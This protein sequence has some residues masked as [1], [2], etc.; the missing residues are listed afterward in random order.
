MEM[1]GWQPDNFWHV[2]NFAVVPEPTTVTLVGL[3]LTGLLV[4]SR[5]RKAGG[6]TGSVGW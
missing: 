2:T 5:R 6:G 1:E 4:G 3:G